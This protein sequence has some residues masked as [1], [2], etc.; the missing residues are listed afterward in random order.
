MIWHQRSS[1]GKTQGWFLVNTGQLRSE[2][3]C[4]HPDAHKYPDAH[5]CA[6]ARTHAHT[7]ALTTQTHMRVHHMHTC[8]PHTHVRTPHTCTHTTR[9]YA[10]NLCSIIPLKS[11]KWL[12]GFSAITE[13]YS[14]SLPKQSSKVLLYHFHAIWTPMIIFSGWTIFCRATL[15]NAT[16]FIGNFFCSRQKSSLPSALL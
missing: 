3:S 1:H 11:M 8:A 4:S 7:R 12:Q 9:T 13:K 2:P 10:R 15:K 6:G 16:S 5:K 14:G